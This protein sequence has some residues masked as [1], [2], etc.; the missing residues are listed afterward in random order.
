M[1]LLELNDEPG[2]Y[3]P[4]YYA[5]TANRELGLRRLE[6][7]LRVDVC[8]IGGGYTGL[9]AA[10]NL[11]EQGVDVV[12]L[13]ASRIGFGASGRNGGQ[14]GSGQRVDQL[15]LE[16]EL[17]SDKARLLW[18]LGEEAKAT[19]RDRIA[20]HEIDCDLKPGQLHADVKPRYLEDR[21]REVDLLRE[22]YGYDQITFADHDTMAEY[23]GSEAYAGGAMDWGAGHLHPLNYALGLASAAQQAGARLFEMSRVLS[24]E[25]GARHDIVTEAG[26][27]D[28]EYLIYACNGYLGDLGGPAEPVARRVMPINNFIA[29]T[30]P[31]GETKARE[32]IRD[33]V[34]V[35]DSKFVVNYYRMTSDHRLLFGGGE[36]YRYKFPGDIGA[37]VRPNMTEIYPQL[38]DVRF[39]YV[40]GGT[41]GI[42]MSRMPHFAQLSPTVFSA[43]GFSGHGVPT[44]SLA[45]K[46][47]AERVAGQA[48]RFDL[49]AGL[50]H[51]TF[52]GGPKFRQP[53]LVLAMTWYALRDRL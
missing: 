24:V 11:A 34:C 12:L 29:V 19:V 27:V 4:S 10:L 15:S 36:T 47:L 39:D 1:D 38:A 40:W 23:L 53:L 49:Y 2:V 3:P 52:P 20:L 42:T 51:R 32:L 22:R 8:V 37:V 26:R 48:G 16:A 25:T 50:K 7:P 31:L 6:A 14:L 45:G 44:A 30:E 18:D 43:A 35:A 5:A 17:G 13:E 41:L 21:K 9:S 28:A 33:D 46:I